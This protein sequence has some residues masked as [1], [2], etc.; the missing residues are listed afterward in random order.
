MITNNNFSS[1][2]AYTPYIQ[3]NTAH[4]QNHTDVNQA[5]LHAFSRQNSA[6]DLS[7]TFS[8]GPQHTAYQIETEVEQALLDEFNSDDEESFLDSIK[9]MNSSSKD[10][11]D[12]TNSNRSQNS[13][14]EGELKIVLNYPPSKKKG[15]SSSDLK[16]QFPQELLNKF[17]K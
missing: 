14:S 8:F 17:K 5:A 1:S 4:P 12:S 11:L 3:E 15:Q 13:S 16:I 9:E 2:S 10:S 7:R 6:F